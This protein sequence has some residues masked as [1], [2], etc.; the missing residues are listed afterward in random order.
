MVL[1]VGAIASGVYPAFV[2]SSFNTADVIK[3]SVNAGSH[4]VALRKV[5]V[6]AQFSCSLCLIIG[7]WAMTKQILFMVHADKGVNTEGVLVLS[8]PENVSGELGESMHSFKHALENLSAVE[9][10]SRC[11]GVR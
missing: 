7:T 10:V 1:L 11:E 8:G 3:G 5:L 9:R 6:I 4:V 2:L